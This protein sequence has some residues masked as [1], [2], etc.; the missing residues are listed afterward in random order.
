[1]KQ[2]IRTGNID[3]IGK[4]FER[5]LDAMRY[6]GSTKRIH[7]SV[8][9]WIKDSLENYDEEDYTVEAGKRFIDDF[10]LQSQH[11]P[12]YYNA[13]KAAVGHLNA[14]LEGRSFTAKF[15]VPSP[16]CPERFRQYKDGYLKHLK[17]KGLKD[18][19]LVN[20][21]RY[22]VY[23]LV[24][25]DEQ[26][27]GSLETL[28]AF[29]LYEHFTRP[30]FKPCSLGVTR[31]FLGHLYDEGVTMSD[32]RACVPR[33]KR[34]KLLPSVYSRDEVSRVL[35]SVDRS[36]AMG[37]RDYAVLVL[38]SKLG[39]R[40]SDIMGLR[41]GDIDRKHA[42]ISIVQKKTGRPLKLVLNR[43]VQ[44]AIDDYIDNGRPSSSSDKV[45]LRTNAP[46]EPMCDSA[47]YSIANKYFD[48]ANIESVGRRRGP[49]ALRAS[50]ATS[51][52]NKGIPYPIV[53]EAL[54]HVDPESISHYARI[55]IRRL[56]ICALKV[57]RPTGSFAAI[58]GDLEG[59]L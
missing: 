6:A 12:S 56:R 50:Y 18:C 31:R 11:R 47:G 35:A 1:M 10:L 44:E 9:G 28:K 16:E 13:A 49:Q 57:P 59:R 38:A 25:L 43:D 20:H 24:R 19:T 30:G 23:L 3:E 58:L 46:F 14:I 36:I 27:V 33:L 52:V 54:G 48:M 5:R 51:L 7:L 17:K 2:Q 39:L 22:A 29:D 26:K 40:S 42:V 41:I 34:K 8:F 4:E 37:K 32:L 15:L 55:D 45:F 21:R 53:R